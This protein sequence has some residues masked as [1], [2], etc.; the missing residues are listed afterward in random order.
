[1]G[2]FDILA[3]A[4]GGM[5][6]GQGGQAQAAGGAQA[7]AVAAILQMLQAHP[8]GVGGIVSALQQCG[9]GAAVGSWIAGGPNQPVSAQEIEAA[10]PNAVG[11]VASQLGVDPTTAAGHVAQ[12]L[13]QILDHLT[14]SG[15]T[16]A[17]GG[18]GALGGL[19]SQLGVAAR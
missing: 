11:Q 10:L 8:G 18:M 6:A 5:L 9:L 17:D 15:Q 19:L 7:S 3:S 4:A 2:L 16:P 1:M 12:L 14:P 13:P